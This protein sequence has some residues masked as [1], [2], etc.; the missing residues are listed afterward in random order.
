MRCSICAPPVRSRSA[1]IYLACMAGRP[2][3]AAGTSFM[4]A[5]RACPPALPP[6]CRCHSNLDAPADSSAP[7]AGSC[8]SHPCLLL[9]QWRRQGSGSQVPRH[10]PRFA[11]NPGVEVPPDEQRMCALRLPCSC[12]QRVVETFLVPVRLGCMRRRATNR[13]QGCAA[14]LASMRRAPKGLTA[15]RYSQH[16]H[17]KVLHCL[18]RHRRTF[19]P[20][21]R[22]AAASAAVPQSTPVLQYHS[23]ALGLR[24]VGLSFLQREQVDARSPHPL[25]DPLALAHF[26]DT[27]NVPSRCCEAPKCCLPHGD[28]PLTGHTLDILRLPW[29]KILAPVAPLIFSPRLSPAG[30][31]S[32]PVRGC[33]K[34]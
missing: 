24:A 27:P 18:P 4:E 33:H 16:P 8:F 30:V 20:S 14:K 28:P 17:P 13:R 9:R 29:P 6:C 34:F 2:R 1:D 15:C 7:C 32:P 3:A 26:A 12:S 10:G 31:L 21:A 25:F 22:K 11:Q 23:L 5:A 19:Q